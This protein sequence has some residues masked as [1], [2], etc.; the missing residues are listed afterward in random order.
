MYAT[1]CGCALPS[2]EGGSA[3]RR[4]RRLAGRG[5]TAT[6]RVADVD[7]EEAALV[8]MS[9]E[10]RELLLALDD[11]ASVVDL[12]VIDAGSLPRPSG[13]YDRVLKRVGIQY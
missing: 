8:I 10:Q 5:T 6:G 12:R 1:A 13:G 2:G 9:V 4:R 11:I 7:R 3:A